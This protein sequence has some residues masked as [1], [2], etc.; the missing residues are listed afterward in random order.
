M[1][2]TA[3]LT[4]RKCPAE[5]LEPSEVAESES[6]SKRFWASRRLRRR[7]RPSVRTQIL[8]PAPSAAFPLADPSYSPAFSLPPLSPYYGASQPT[9]RPPHLLCWIFDPHLNPL[10]SK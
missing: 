1:V 9:P 3:E 2:D 6:K 5:G 8:A 4:G 7:E 10:T